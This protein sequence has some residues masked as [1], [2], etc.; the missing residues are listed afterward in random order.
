MTA[1]DCYARLRNLSLLSEYT[2]GP[3]RLMISGLGL[4]QKTDHPEVRSFLTGL[5]S[6]MD[7]EQF[8]PCDVIEVKELSGIIS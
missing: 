4:L 7:S 3:G 8:N 6:Y 5:L 1:L 2:V